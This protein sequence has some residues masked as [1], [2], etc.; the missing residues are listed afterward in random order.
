MQS[1]NPTNP[2]NAPQVNPGGVEQQYNIHTNVAAQEKA[3]KQDDALLHAYLHGRP[4]A[5]MELG[6]LLEPGPGASNADLAAADMSKVLQVK[7]TAEQAEMA[8]LVDKPF[9]NKPFGLFSGEFA[10]R[11]GFHLLGTT[12]TWLL[13]AVLLLSRH[14]LAAFLSSSLTT[15][16]AFLSSS[17]TTAAVEA[18]QRHS[19]YNQCGAAWPRHLFPLVT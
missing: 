6:L 19:G 17:L 2:H 8:S 9:T 13:D 10:R 5:R 14:L 1:T 12:S 3:N 11:H 7:I 16:A 18:V 4:K 15:A